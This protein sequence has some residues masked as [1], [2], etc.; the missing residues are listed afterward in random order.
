MRGA[1]QKFFGQEGL[2]DLNTPQQGPPQ[3][4][5]ET[6]ITPTPLGRGKLGLWVDGI[7]P[8]SG[9]GIQGMR[10]RPSKPSQTDH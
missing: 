6:L 9:H 10:E 1:A 3:P 4:R 8:S 2:E 7:L 5:V